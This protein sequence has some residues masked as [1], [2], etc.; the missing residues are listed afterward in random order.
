MPRWMNST[1]SSSTQS[2]A[3]PPDPAMKYLSL[4]FFS[5]CPVSVRLVE[6]APS[7]G[8]PIVRSSLPVVA[9]VERVSVHLA[10][11]NPL[12]RDE[13]PN[14]DPLDLL[15]KRHRREGEPGKTLVGQVSRFQ[16]RRRS[17]ALHRLEDDVRNL[18][19]ERFHGGGIVGGQWHRQV[20]NAE[21]GAWS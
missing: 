7:T 14:V 16:G 15:L 3:S 6:T 1:A 20:R 12:A 4:R 18:F 17:P 2:P 8:R 10:G 13:D 11:E 5:A 19:A 21:F 9:K